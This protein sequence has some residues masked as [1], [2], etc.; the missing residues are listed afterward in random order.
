VFKQE[1]GSGT[2]AADLDRAETAHLPDDRIR[3]PGLRLRRDRFGDQASVRLAGTN[4]SADA[5]LLPIS[6]DHVLSW[7]WREGGRPRDP[8]AARPRF[9]VPRGRGP[10]LSLRG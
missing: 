5:S 10:G 9:G 6:G 8:V 4:G 3:L 2:A 1:I 7:F